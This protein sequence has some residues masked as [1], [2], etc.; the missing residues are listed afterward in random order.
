[1]SPESTR[2]RLY[3]KLSDRG[4]PI[5]ARIS[6]T[7][8]RRGLR[9][10]LARVEYDARRIEITRLSTPVAALV[11]IQDLRQL[12]AFERDGV[13]MFR[14]HLS[15]LAAVRRGDYAGG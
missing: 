14:E 1:M 4:M 15:L 7:D 12:E 10:V 3:R 6:A 9:E 11:P 8:T 5:P 13:S 2:Y